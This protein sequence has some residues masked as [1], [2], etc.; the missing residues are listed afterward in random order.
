MKMRTKTCPT[1]SSDFSYTVGRGNDRKHCSVACAAMHQR[2]LKAQRPRVPCALG[3]GR[4]ARRD[5]RTICEACYYYHRRTGK[6]GPAP[7]PAGRRKNGAGYVVVIRP[8]HPLANKNREAFEHR[9]VA[10][11]SHHGICPNCFWCD[12]R[13]TWRAAVVDHLNEDKADNDP[14]NLVVAC[15]SC[16]LTRGGMLP[17]LARIT[18]AAFPIFL[19]CVTSY[20]AQVAEVARC[21]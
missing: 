4:Q 19:G 15:N 13:L 3:C 1:C 7:A 10:Y 9:V 18:E 16:N 12:V 5:Q 17:F 20:R 21:A 11:D 2:S 8:G 14:S 6:P